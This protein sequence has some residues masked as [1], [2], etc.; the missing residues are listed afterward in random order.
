MRTW[1]LKW[2]L[3]RASVL[4]TKIT[5]PKTSAQ[6]SFDPGVVQIYHSLTCL[7]WD[8]HSEFSSPVFEQL[9]ASLLPSTAEP[10]ELFPI[11][12]VLLCWQL[13]PMGTKAQSQAVSSQ[14]LLWQLGRKQQPQTHWCT[15]VPIFSP[16]ESLT[17][18]MV[19]KWGWVVFC[20]YFWRV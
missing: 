18:K 4:L 17:I 15:C 3:G 7:T 2:V 1:T 20:N 6:K 16:P 9:S 8:L 19:G 10:E 13:L 5:I 14:V 11:P 12:L